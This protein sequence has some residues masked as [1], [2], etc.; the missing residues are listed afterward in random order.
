MNSPN[1]VVFDTDVLVGASTHDVGTWRRYPTVPPISP[2]PYADCL[3]IVGDPFAGDW[4][5][6][7]SVPLLEFVAADLIGRHH[8]DERLAEQYVVRL[9]EIAEAS[10]GGVVGGRQALGSGAEP[11]IRHVW[12]AA[13]AVEAAVVVSGDDAVRRH[14]PWPPDKGGKPPHGT[15]SFPAAEFRHLVDRARRGAAI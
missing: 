6:W 3:G 1:R 4:A 9:G 2:S 15:L 5:L 11:R 7:T 10:G 13:V 8:W 14:S 12:G